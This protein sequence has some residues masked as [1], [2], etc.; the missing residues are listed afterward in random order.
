MIILGGSLDL[1]NEGELSKLLWF[2]MPIMQL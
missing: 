2:S 1:V